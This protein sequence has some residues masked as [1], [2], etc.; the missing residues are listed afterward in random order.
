MPKSKQAARKLNSSQ[1]ARRKS[2]LSMGRDAA[3][4]KGV[5]KR[6]KISALRRESQFQARLAVSR[7]VIA[8][9]AAVMKAGARFPAPLV[10]K[11]EGEYWVV[12]GFH[13]IAAAELAGL[14]H[15]E[16]LVCEGSRRD[17]LLAAASANASHG[18]QRTT[19]DKRRAIQMLLEDEEWR[20]WS[21]TEI[22]RRVGVTDKTVAAVRNG[23]DGTLGNSESTGKNP[24]DEKRTYRR[25]G[26][27]VQRAARTRRHRN[28]QAGDDEAA[29]ASTATTD[30]D[31]D[32]PADDEQDADLTS[33]MHNI[34]GGTTPDGDVP[35]EPNADPDTSWA[36]ES[37]EEQAANEIDSRLAELCM[38][39]SRARS[40][41]V[42]ALADL[43]DRQMV[44]QAR[45]LVPELRLLA[46][47]IAAALGEGGSAAQTGDKSEAP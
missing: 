29:T 47:E 30:A 23:H 7:E 6:M 32:Q 12:D 28:Q 24:S 13:T 22:A 14:Q 42:P 15:I 26:S 43:T 40:E 10:Y 38:D 37:A 17:A 46:D 39:L 1:V 34:T 3:T 44:R 33:A 16:V 5:L 8:N 20:R 4:V 25:N 9:Y 45:S 18:L 21:D 2:T 27:L 36:A 19:A 35:D 41:V 11:F 31:T